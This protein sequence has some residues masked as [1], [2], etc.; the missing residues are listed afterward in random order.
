MIHVSVSIS[1]ARGCWNPL[2]GST[3]VDVQFVWLASASVTMAL[4]PFLTAVIVAVLSWGVYKLLQI[5]KRDPRLPPGPPTLPVLGNIH[6]IPLTGLYKK[7]VWQLLS[8]LHPKLIG[9]D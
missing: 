9:T 4:S 8:T 6:Q 1:H 3:V 5:G 7:S 2:K